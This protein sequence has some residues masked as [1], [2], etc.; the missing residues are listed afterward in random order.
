MSNLIVTG[1]DSVYVPSPPQGKHFS[2]PWR[3]KAAVLHYTLRND[4]RRIFIRDILRE[5]QDRWEA[6]FLELRKNQF[7]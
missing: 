3:A 7:A 5:I 1:C 2:H 6:R 4:G